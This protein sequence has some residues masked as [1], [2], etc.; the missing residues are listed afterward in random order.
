[1]K[2]DVMRVA[3]GLGL[4]LV[5]GGCT[6]VSNLM[7]PYYEPPSELAMQGEKN[8]HAISGQKEKVDEARQALEAMASYRRTHY[9]QP[10]DPVVQPAVVRLMWIPDHLNTTT[11]SK[12]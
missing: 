10:A 11:T 7:N 2:M 6:Q 4:T 9:P 12:F 3:I 5:T 8:D 1:M